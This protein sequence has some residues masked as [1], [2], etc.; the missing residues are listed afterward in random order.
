[1]CWGFKVQ[2]LKMDFINGGILLFTAARLIRIKIINCLY[3]QNPF[4]NFW[5]RHLIC[6]YRHCVYIGVLSLKKVQF[7]LTFTVSESWRDKRREGELGWGWWRWMENQIW[8]E[9]EGYADLKGVAQFP[10]MFLS[11][12]FLH[13]C[14]YLE[15][16]SKSV[17]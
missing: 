12:I 4:S 10:K 1:M 9:A 2:N 7:N 14:H 17:K 13:T 8:K 3:S 11:E 5:L 16:K 15:Q 6:C